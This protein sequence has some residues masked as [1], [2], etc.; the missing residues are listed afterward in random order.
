M[1]DSLL[2]ITATVT[3]AIALLGGAALWFLSRSAS[4]PPSASTAR[5]ATADDRQVGETSERSSARFLAPAGVGLAVVVLLTLATN[6]QVAGSPLLVIALALV[7]VGLA[8]YSYTTAPAGER[9]RARWAAAAAVLMFLTVALW[10]GQD[11][12]R[13][14]DQAQAAAN[15]LSPLLQERDLLEAR[16]I[17]LERRLTELRGNQT[18]NRDRV[19]AARSLARESEAAALCELD[20]TCGAGVPGVSE[21]YRQKQRIADRARADLADAEADLREGDQAL[22]AALEELAVL[23]NQA[24]PLKQRIAVEGN[25]DM[26]VTSYLSSSPAPLIGAILTIGSIVLMVVRARRRRTAS[27]PD[28]RA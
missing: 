1:P 4:G 15:R 6:S 7:T 10:I 21:S 14:S 13:Y 9:R 24:A 26:G 8:V 11:V 12:A 23:E 28:D 22:A 27:E 25:G 17:S 5:L 19:E 16:T 3:G 2:E 20:G 18:W